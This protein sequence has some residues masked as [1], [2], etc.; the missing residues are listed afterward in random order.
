MEQLLGHWRHP[1][2]ILLE[3]GHIFGFTAGD[4][5]NQN[6]VI[7]SQKTLWVTYLV[8]LDQQTV[9]ASDISNSSS[10]HV[11]HGET[12]VVKYN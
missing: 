11:Q 9:S 6:S 7:N 12:A 8:P 10:A 1:L 4:P 2:V 5:Y 3:C